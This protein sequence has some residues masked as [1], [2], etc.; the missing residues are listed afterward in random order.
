MDS[1]ETLASQQALAV[2]GEILYHEG[3]SLL[4]LSTLHQSLYMPLLAGRSAQ[5]PAKCK[6]LWHAIALVWM[7]FGRW[8]GYQYG[9][10]WQH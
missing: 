3:A 7:Q 1:A 8:F 5:E 9:Y 2:Q 6:C 10:G 4:E